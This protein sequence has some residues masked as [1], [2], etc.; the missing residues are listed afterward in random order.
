VVAA[1]AFLVVAPDRRNRET[2]LQPAA[3]LAI[4]EGYGIAIVGRS[5]RAQSVEP[6]SPDP[7]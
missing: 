7:L 5:G 6:V 4:N 2:L 3:S 1:G